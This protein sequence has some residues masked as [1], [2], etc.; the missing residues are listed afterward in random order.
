MIER[1]PRAYRA[2]ALG[3][4]QPRCRCQ[5]R[6]PRQDECGCRPGLRERRAR[7]QLRVGV[8]HLLRATT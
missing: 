6:Y 1:R 7:R 5:R 2:A 8:S 4:R 3:H